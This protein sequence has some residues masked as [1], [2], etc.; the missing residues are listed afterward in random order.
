MEKAD[1]K[2][3]NQKY[4][5]EIIE[6]RKKNNIPDWKFYR[7]IR[8]GMTP[9]EAATTPYEPFY[10]PE[11]RKWSKV[12]ESN[13]INPMTFNTRVKKLGW[14][15]EK[16]SA[17]PPRQTK[18]SDW[19]KKAEANGINRSTFNSRKQAGWDLE[20]A[21]TQPPRPIPK[22]QKLL[23]FAVFKGGEKLCEGTAQ[24]CAK[25]LGVKESTIRW[26]TTQSYHKRLEERQAQHTSKIAF[27]V[28]ESN[29]S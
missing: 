1:K 26:M 29:E 24:E 18:Y 2:W 22:R 21:C 17:T 9:Y 25:K 19:E 4:P 10:D 3:D 5:T 16:A 6:L 27:K 28:G 8:K 23:R 20:R 12:A 14:S 11:Y 7:R 13:G 15:Y